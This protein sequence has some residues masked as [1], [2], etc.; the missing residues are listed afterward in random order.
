VDLKIAGTEDYIAVQDMVI[1][2]FEESPY[3]D[4]PLDESKIS[5]V[6]LDFL[7]NPS[8]KIVIL[9]LE[10]NEPVGMISGMA[11]EHLFSRE[12]TAFE[13]VWW[14]YP[15]KRGL[16]SS[17]KLFEAFEYWAKKVGCKYVQF[18]AAQGT[19]YSDKVDQLYK[20]RGYQKTE[21]NYLK[22]I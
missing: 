3:K 4:L 11:S 5:S 17:L 19:P 6:V 9:A 14:V 21:S 8:E 10:D 18:G 15:E 2:F 16:R 12:K 22:V 1:R 20:R 7:S 13:T